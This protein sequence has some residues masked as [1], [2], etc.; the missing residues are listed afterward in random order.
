MS[1]DNAGPHSFASDGFNGCTGIVIASERGA[2][3]GHYF[4]NPNGVNTAKSQLPPLIQAN[5]GALNPGGQAYVYAQVDY[6][7]QSQ[8]HAPDVKN[9]LVQ[10]L[11]ANGFNPIIT[12]YIEPLAIFVD[13]DGDVIDDIDM[14]NA[15]YG[16]L[17]VSNAGGGT[18]RTDVRF[19]SIAVQ[20]D[21]VRSNPSA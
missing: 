7:N 9:Q 14:D 19:I 13:A 8:F 6:E 16:S 20:E 15:Q 12:T 5:S 3:I 21:L 17:I 4:S 10:L 1:F 2:I 11:Q 18:S